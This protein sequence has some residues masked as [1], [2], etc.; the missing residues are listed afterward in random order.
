MDFPIKMPSWLSLGRTIFTFEYEEQ[1][2]DIRTIQSSGCDNYL[3]LI[4]NLFNYRNILTISIMRLNLSGCL[5]FLNV[6]YKRKFHLQRSIA[7]GF[8]SLWVIE[9]KCDFE[10][11]A[12]N[13]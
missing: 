3:H 6:P 5:G 1:P 2:F 4:V 13:E 10:I 9:K 7:V 11:H 12:W 8:T